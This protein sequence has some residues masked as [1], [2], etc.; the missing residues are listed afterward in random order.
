MKSIAW[1]S[2]SVNRSNLEPELGVR[3]EMLAEQM[4]FDERERKRVPA[5]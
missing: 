3:M 1:P 4:W 2:V 5:D